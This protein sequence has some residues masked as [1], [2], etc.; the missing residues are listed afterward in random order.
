MFPSNPTLQLYCSVLS[1]KPHIQFPN[2]K[3]PIGPLHANHVRCK[4][5]RYFAALYSPRH[6]NHLAVNLFKNVNLRAHISQQSNRIC[7]LLFTK[8]TKHPNS[9]PK[10]TYDCPQQFSRKVIKRNLWT[11]SYNE[12]HKYRKTTIV[13][14]CNQISKKEKDN[15]TNHNKIKKKKKKKKKIIIREDLIFDNS[16]SSLPLKVSLTWRS[17]ISERE[18]SWIE[19]DPCKIFDFSKFSSNSFKK[20]LI[21]FFLSLQIDQTLTILAALTTGFSLAIASRPAA[22]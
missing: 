14:I 16:L 18:I 3:S 6:F 4:N 10:F 8:K 1:F 13:F 15:I 20:F 17:L 19:Y 7:Q 9:A 2:G 22:L 5:S 11:S 12:H 21:Y